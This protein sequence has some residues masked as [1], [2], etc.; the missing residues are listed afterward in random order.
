AG[1]LIVG[2]LVVRQ[3]MLASVDHPTLVA[4]GLTRA[5]VWWSAMLAPTLVGIVGA[6]LGVLVAFVLS[7][8]APIGL[9]QIAEPRPGF[10]FD[11]FPRRLC[12]LVT[13]V[14]VVGIAAWP[15]WRA[16]SVAARGEQRVRGRR[17]RW[18]VAQVLTQTDAPA[19]ATEGVRLAF[20]RGR[21]RTSVP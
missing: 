11:A 21:G 4:L 10:A 13:V 20:E 3:E 2:Q 8:L 16:A 6:S 7:P 17:R 5:D 18:N 19:T 12:A 14:L 15:A 9:A 1:V